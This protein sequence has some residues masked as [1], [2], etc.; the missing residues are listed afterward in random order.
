MAF[1]DEFTR[2]ASEAVSSRVDKYTTDNSTTN[3]IAGGGAAYLGK[4]AVDSISMWIT[5]GADKART[6]F[7][8]KFI[9]YNSEIKEKLDKAV[10][11]AVTR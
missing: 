5:A 11:I 10:D 9:G 7:V 6:N 2:G 3:P 8:Q 1:W 4:S